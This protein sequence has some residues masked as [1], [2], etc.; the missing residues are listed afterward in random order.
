[1]IRHEQR[2]VHLVAEVSVIDLLAGRENDSR[3]IRTQYHPFGIPVGKH[4]DDSGSTNGKA[5]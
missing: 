1:V 3:P 2:A 4:H 5:R